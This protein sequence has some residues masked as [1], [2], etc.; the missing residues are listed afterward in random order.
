[1][2][3]V[4]LLL[5]TLFGVGLSF[6][7]MTDPR[8]VL[9]FLDLFGDWDPT[10]VFVMASGVATTF[11]AYRL[12]LKREKPIFSA[13]FVLPNNIKIDRNLILG[14]VLFGIGWGL[15]GYCPGPAIASLSY[16]NYESFLFVAAM[17]AG[18]WIR[19]MQAK[20]QLVDN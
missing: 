13:L 16:L 17:L 1:M 9:G 8:K 10:L 20:R 19:S 7:G 6:S 15:Y 11:I 14:A 3:I 5:G 2:K 12:I 4:Y 18:S